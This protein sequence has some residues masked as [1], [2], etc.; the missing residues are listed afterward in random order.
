MKKS[1]LSLI[2]AAC[3]AVASAGESELLA[4]NTVLAV[5]EN[6]VEQ[7]CRF[8]TADCPDRCDHATRAAIFRVLK[9]EDYA[10]PGQYGDDKMEEGAHVYINIRKDEPGQAPEIRKLISE[11]KPGDQVRMTVH[12]N[13]IKDESA[14]YP[15]RP[16]VQMERI[17]AASDGSDVKHVQQ[18]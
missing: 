4:R 6:T 2:A 3:A 15:A 11:L 13:Y 18:P 5:Y 16:V 1:I 10:K 9:N 12:H 17:P 7:P 8:M 14:H